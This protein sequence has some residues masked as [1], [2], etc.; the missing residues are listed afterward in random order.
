MNYG[1]GGRRL[2]VGLLGGNDGCPRRHTLRAAAI[3][4]ASGTARCRP[5]LISSF[6][7]KSG[8]S[9]LRAVWLIVVGRVQLSSTLAAEASSSFTAEDRDYWAW[10]PCVRAAVPA[11]NDQA[12]HPIDA[13]LLERLDRG[14]GFAAPE[15]DRRTLIRRA[16]FDLHGLPPTPEEVA[17]FEADP[18]PDAY[19][20]LIDR[21]LA[22]PRYGEH[23]GPAT[24]STWC[25]TPRATASSRDD[26]RRTPGAI[27]I[28]SSAPSTRTRR[29]DR[30]MVE[31]LAGD[32]LR[33]D[34]PRRSMATG[35][36]R[37]GSV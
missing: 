14:R 37:L 26:L 25:A 28:T 11:V 22:S 3:D 2:S 34:D 30:F 4:P 13:F 7:A 33:P 17:Q 8:S 16:T 12:A 10:Q 1:A 6:D 20:R 31:Q 23:V 9:P 19:E 32:E 15:A 36:L 27:A 5:I 24:G 18:A 35:Y 29:F 21:L